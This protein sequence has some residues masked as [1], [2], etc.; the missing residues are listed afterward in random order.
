[1][2][3]PSDKTAETEPTCH[4]S[5]GMIRNLNNSSNT[6]IIIFSDKI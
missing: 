5:W 3:V 1:M 6:K 2:S 4:R